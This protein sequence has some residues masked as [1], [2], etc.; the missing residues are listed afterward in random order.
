MSHFEEAVTDPRIHRADA[1]R[2]MADE[3]NLGRWFLGRYSVS[4]T[5]GSQGP[6]LVDRA[7]PP[8]AW[9]FSLRSWPRGPMPARSRGMVEGLRRLYTPKRVAIVTLRRG[10]YPSGSAFEFMPQ[11]TGRYVR[12]LR[13]T[14]TQSDLVQQLNDF[15]PHTLVSYASVLDT[16]AVAS[17]RLHLDHP[18]PDRQRQRTAHPGRPPP[19]G[20][21]LR[22][23]G[24]RSLRDRRVPAVG[25]WLPDRRR[26]TRQ[27]RLVHFGGGRRELPAGAARANWGTRC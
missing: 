1:E 26:G 19:P 17:D 23:A 12:M 25:R 16:L 4:H 7:G 13:L 21:G 11:F 18:P 10:F 15:Q 6:P 24:L 14:S 2:F 5:S 20:R 3:G 27:L 8:G 22:R 9:P